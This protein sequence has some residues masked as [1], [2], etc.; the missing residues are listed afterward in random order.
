MP[1]Q[2]YIPHIAGSSREKDL[3]EYLVLSHRIF[4][5][6]ETLTQKEYTLQK[7]IKF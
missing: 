1:A 7:I 6:L 3:P 5:S 4:V 2:S